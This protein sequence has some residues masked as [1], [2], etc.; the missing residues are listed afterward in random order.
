MKK[1]RIIAPSSPAKK[2]IDLA[3]LNAFFAPLG[4]TVE[5]G[6]NVHKSRRYLAGTIQERLDDLHDAFA[7]PS[8]SIIMALRGGA[9]AAA[10]LDGIR[11][12]LIKNNPKPFY[13]FSDTTALQLPFYDKAG[14][15]GF[16]GI[17]PNYNPELF[18]DDISKIT[19]D[20]FAASLR[21]D[22]VS[23]PIMP[24]APGSKEKHHALT[25]KPHTLLPGTMLLITDL[26]GTPYQPDF[27]N[28]I[29]VLEESDSRLDAIERMFI[30]LDQCGCFTNAAAVVFGVFTR[31]HCTMPQYGTI[32]DTLSDWARHLSDKYGLPVFGGLPYKHLGGSL[33]LPIGGS[34]VIKDNIL[35]AAPQKILKI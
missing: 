19:L 12:D 28:T 16:S 6:K 23:H 17:G 32:Q 30:Q 1:L 3:F 18:S 31:M 4:L 33:V 15:L 8:V 25:E 22:I 26:M 21:F 9:G 34:A 24:L 10:M 29:M 2:P 7:D 14:L 13:G 20:S 11:W 27:K 5:L 35:T